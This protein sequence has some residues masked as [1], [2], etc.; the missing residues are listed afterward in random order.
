MR[1]FKPLLFAGVA[2]ALGTAAAQAQPYYPPGPPRPHYWHQGDYYRGHQHIVH[3]WRRYHLP[4]PAP[5]T[6]W[7]Q[8]G[9]NFLLLSH[10]GFIVRV[11]AP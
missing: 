7:V 11:W 6:V 2:L 3:H 10:G 9:P 4:P 8:D 5:G 1:G